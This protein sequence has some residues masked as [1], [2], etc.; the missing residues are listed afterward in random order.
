MVSDKQVQKYRDGLSKGQPKGAAALTAGMDPKTA[1]KWETGPMPSDPRLPRTW[2]TRVSGLEPLWDSQVVPLLRRDTEDLLQAT[3]ILEHLKIAAPEK[4]DDSLLRTLQ[5]RMRDWRALHGHEKEVYFEQEHP[6]GREVQ[7]DF[8]D[9]TRLGV[10]IQGT[11]LQHKLFEMELSCSGR[12]YVE[13]AYAETFEALKSGIQNGFWS[14]G[15]VARVVRSD[16]LSAATHELPGGGRELN[17][18]FEALLQHYKVES[19]RIEPG[20]SNQNGGVERGH[21]VLKNK[22]DQALRLRA[23]RDFASVAAWMAVVDREVQKLNQACHLEF[24]LERPHL[25]PLPPARIPDYTETEVKV[26][27]F[28]IIR[29]A[30]NGYSVP[31]RLIGHEVTVRLY[32]EQVVVLYAG[33]EQL[34]C[35]RLH[36]QDQVRVN[37]RHIIHSLVRK[38]GAFARYRWREELFPSLVFRRAYDALAERRGERADAAYLKIL[39][40]AA[41]TM[42]CD[43]EAALEL[44]LEQARPFDF[45]EVQSLVEARLPE[46]WAA[47]ALSPLTP[48]LSAYDELLEDLDA[49]NAPVVEPPGAA[50]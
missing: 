9:C 15:G 30:R 31:S 50:P 19:T 26:S 7:V 10:T 48:F 43:V 40:L 12:R 18:R 45:R 8:T 20:K 21:G 35:E 32:P 44:L 13:L 33:K 42:Q 29:A 4:V 3:T 36:G 25:L 14:L 11:P 6:P 16:N 39:E 24:L 22:L 17:A 2:K 47:H 27:R 46:T 37:Y 5:R 28:S 41:K 38:P 49:P 34:R 23:S 1:R